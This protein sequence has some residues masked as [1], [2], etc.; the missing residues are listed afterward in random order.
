MSAT[1]LQQAERARTANWITWEGKGPRP[2]AANT[3]VTVLSRDGAAHQGIAG[4]WCWSWLDLPDF[5]EPDD[6]IAYRT[7]FG[8]AREMT[9]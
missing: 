2:V 3:K 9:S 5:W 8:V 6:I 1:A 7:R 4:Q